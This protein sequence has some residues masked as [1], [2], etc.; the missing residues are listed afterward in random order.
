MKLAKTP[1]C[2]ARLKK[3][4]GLFSTKDDWKVT[5]HYVVRT[6]AKGRI[7]CVR[8][9]NYT[10]PSAPYSVFHLSMREFNRLFRPRTKQEYAALMREVRRE[11]LRVHG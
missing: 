3:P 7:A 4:E 5:A 6:S 1:P 11:M 2:M 10:T 9:S 8:V